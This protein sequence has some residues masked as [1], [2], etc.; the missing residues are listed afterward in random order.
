MSRP[1]SR[2][3]PIARDRRKG[4]RHRGSAYAR[5]THPPRFIPTT[6]APNLALVAQKIDSRPWLSHLINESRLTPRSRPHSFPFI[7]SRHDISV[8]PQGCPVLPQGW[9]RLAEEEGRQDGEGD[10]REAQGRQR[11]I[12]QLLLR[13]RRGKR[14]IPAPMLL[15]PR[16]RRGRRAGPLP[17]HHDGRRRQ[18]RRQG[19]SHHT[20]QPNTQPSDSG[21]TD[22]GDRNGFRNLFRYASGA[23]QMSGSGY[24]EGSMSMGMGGEMPASPMMHSPARVSVQGGSY[25]PEV[26]ANS[27]PYGVVGGSFSQHQHGGVPGHGVIPSHYPHGG[28][29]PHALYHAAQ[30]QFNGAESESWFNSVLASGDETEDGN[31]RVRRISGN[32]AVDGSIPRP[33]TFIRPAVQ[34]EQQQVPGPRQHGKRPADGWLLWHGT[35]RG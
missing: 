18:G 10:A 1:G 20:M 8:R 4:R 14:P 31:P 13:A 6:R 17:R 35:R 7:H 34:A 28:S 23:S 27:H 24:D 16:Q 29:D 33:S 30:E 25:H 9:P 15:A 2:A 22:G 11:R 3:N 5:E 32:L 21:T 19:R 26:Y 12:T